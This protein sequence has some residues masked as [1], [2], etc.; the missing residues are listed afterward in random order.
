MNDN[1]RQVGGFVFFLCVFVE[2]KSGELVAVKVFNM[3]SYNRPHEVQMREFEMLRKLNHRNIVRLFAVEEASIAA[4]VESII[5]GTWEVLWRNVIALQNRAAALFHSIRIKELKSLGALS[6]P[7]MARFM[8]FM[9]YNCFC[10]FSFKADCFSFMLTVLNQVLIISKCL[11]LS[12]CP[13]SRRC[14]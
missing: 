14:W 9:H 6:P 3:M 10:R 8:P 12:S 2:Q 7:L 4:E 5:S 1:D 11:N 13:L